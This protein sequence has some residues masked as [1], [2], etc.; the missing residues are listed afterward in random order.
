VHNSSNFDEPA[1]GIDTIKDSVGVA[2]EWQPTDIWLIGSYRRLRKIGQA[3]LV[4][5]PSL[6]FATELTID[7]DRQAA[8]HRKRSPTGMARDRSRPHRRPMDAPRHSRT[9]S[10]LTLPEP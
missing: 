4:L 1:V 2:D 7:M 10:G 3:P 8:K 5:A 9:R 6:S